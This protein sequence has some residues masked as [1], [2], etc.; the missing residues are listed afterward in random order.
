MSAP[1]HTRAGHIL[2]VAM[3]SSPP[4]G[5]SV[6]TSDS[7]SEETVEVEEEPVPSGTTPKSAARP[8]EIRDVG[9]ESTSEDY[10]ERG[11]EAGRHGKGASPERRGE[12]RRPAAAPN[13]EPTTSSEFR[14]RPHGAL[15]PARAWE[16]SQ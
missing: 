14:T 9:S 1:W 15:A 10:R 12:E 5:P 13:P 2:D 6:S 11:P 16:A 3:G 8:K 4:P 7:S